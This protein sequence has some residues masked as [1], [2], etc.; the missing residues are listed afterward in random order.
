MERTTRRD[1]LSG[2][3]LVELLVVIAIIGILVAMLLPAVQSAREAARK[4]QCTSQMKQLGLATLNYETAKKSF[5]WASYVGPPLSGTNPNQTVKHG[6]LP[7]L[8]PYLEE[9]SLADQYDYDQSYSYNS[10]GRNPGQEAGNY[11]LAFRTP[12]PFFHCPTTPGRQPEDPQTDY[13][14]SQRIAADSEH[15]PTTTATAIRDLLRNKTIIERSSWESVLAKR[16]TTQGG[17]VVYKPSRIRDTTDGLSKTFMWFEI[18]GRQTIY[19]EDHAP[20]GGTGTHG[21]S[22]A[23]DDN[24]FWVHERCGSKIFNCNNGEEIYSFHVG[25]AV[26]GLGDGS[27]Q[28]VSNDVSTNVFVSYHTRDEGDLVEGEIF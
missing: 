23:A 17:S 25:G 19:G 18:A 5:P 9:A 26:F 15:W 6:T 10:G 16:R 27:V 2:F 7:F 28:F 20:T 24:E 11:L 3:T 12:L 14:V 21:S 4:M 1:R 22:W 8:L 13:A